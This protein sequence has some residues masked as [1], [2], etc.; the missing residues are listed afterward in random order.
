MRKNNEIVTNN[1]KKK[2]FLILSLNLFKKIKKL[3][4]SFYF[5][6]E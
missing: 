4:N 5:N 3:T 2:G 6:F 1:E